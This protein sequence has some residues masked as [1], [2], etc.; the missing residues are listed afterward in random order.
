MMEF[1]NRFGLI[2]KVWGT[3]FLILSL[4]INNSYSCYSLDN[5]SSGAEM[6][7]YLQSDYEIITNIFVGEL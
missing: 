3:H 7:L 2:K 1:D 4:N 6:N 5:W